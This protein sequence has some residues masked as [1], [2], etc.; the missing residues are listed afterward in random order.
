[1]LAMFATVVAGSAGFEA[2]MIYA[3]KV[4][5]SAQYLP[6]CSRL[7]SGLRPDSPLTTAATWPGCSSSGSRAPSCSPSR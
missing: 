2:G 4:R 7:F 1:M 5:R 6:Q 3:L